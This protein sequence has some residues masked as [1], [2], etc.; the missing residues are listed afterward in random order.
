VPTTHASIALANLGR[1]KE[2]TGELR[3]IDEAATTDKR[4]YTEDETA[5]IEEFRTELT[6]IDERITKNLEMQVTEN[7]IDRSTSAL[8]GQMLDQR[9]DRPGI[10]GRTVG[11][12]LTDTD[13]FRA[14]AERGGQ[15]GHMHVQLPGE[16]R[17]VTDGTLAAGS[18][19]ELVVAP[20][21]PG[22]RMETLDR[23]VALLDLVPHIPVSQASVEYV[24][25]VTPQADMIDVPAIVPERGQKPTGSITLDVITEP[26]KQVAVMTAITRQAAADVPQFVGYIDGRM[27]Y[28]LRRKADQ[29]L[30]GGSGVGNNLL[31][32]MYRPGTNSYTPGSEPRYKSIRSAITMMEQD[33]TIPEIVVLNPADA[34]LFDLANH[35]QAG[36]HAIDADGGMSSVGPRTAWGLRQVRSNAVASGTALLVDPTAVAVFDRQAITAYT[37]DSHGVNFQYNILDL[38]LE[39][40][41][42]LGLFQ[43]QGIAKITF[44]GTT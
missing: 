30:I 16:F 18:A 32:L 6:A 28:A 9:A 1:R 29:Q 37:T 34:E 41:L 39:A 42:G 26:I 10:E 31:G 19:G 24:Q 43:P 22:I 35:S 13:E 38:L 21:L 44:S 11:N 5:K 20:R 3:Q 2:I 36:L 25:D 27:R 12:A 33:E 14:W 4:G 8:L 23:P 15:T 17:A 7:D 40:R